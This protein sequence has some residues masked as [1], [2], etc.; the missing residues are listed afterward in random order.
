MEQ[1]SAVRGTLGNQ[2]TLVTPEAVALDLPLASVGSRGVALLLDYLVVG[3]VIIGLLLG[4]AAL[5]STING[6]PDWVGVT[7]V[8][9]MLTAVQF[10]YPIAFETL[11]RGRTLGKAALGLRVVTVEGGPVRFRHAATRAVLGIVDFQMTLGGAALFTSFLNPRGQRLGDI[12]AGTLVVRERS[13]AGPAVAAT[14]D[15]P[16]GFEATVAGLDVSGLGA[17]EY[18]AVRAYLQRE[19]SLGADTRSGL[20]GEILRRVAPRVQPPLDP[21]LPPSVALHVVAAAVQRRRQT[22]VATSRAQ[23]TRTRTEDPF[24]IDVWSEPRHA[25]RPPTAPS[26]SRRETEDRSDRASAASGAAFTPPD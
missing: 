4:A 24:A 7:L 26:G 5:D 12:V 15:V 10:G 9:V 2:P 11:W 1:R 25:P 19:A 14:F 8:I 18:Q 21:D 16:R 20:A 6:V 22:G 13:G 17:A 23:P 3:A